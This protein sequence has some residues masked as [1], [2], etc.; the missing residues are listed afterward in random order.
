MYSNSRMVI[1][2]SLLIITGFLIASFSSFYVSRTTAIQALVKAEL[3]L[4][5][6]N[7]YTEVQRDLLSPKIVSSVMANDT[8]V[9]NWIKKGEQDESLIAAYLTR[10][11]QKY[12]AFT[13]F[14]VVEKTRNFYVPKGFVRKVATTEPRDEWYFRVRNN[15]QEIEVNIDPSEVNND[16]L[17]IFI[18]VRILDNAGEFIGAIGLGLKLD[19]LKS[20]LKEYKKKYGINVY[21]I[22]REGEIFLNP[23]GETN[24]PNIFQIPGFSDIAGE[25]VKTD[26]GQFRYTNSGTEY[27]L[28]TRYIKDVNLILMVEADLNH[29]TQQAFRSLVLNVFICLVTTLIVLFLLL[30][31]IKQHQ[32]K[33][34]K[35]AWRDYLTK[36]FNREAFVKSYAIQASSHQRNSQPLSILLIDLDHF[37]SINDQF[38]HSVGDQVLIRVADLLRQET[39][40]SDIVARWGGEEFVVL[41]SNADLTVAAALA[42]KIRI[43]IEQDDELQKIARKAQTA[44]IGLALCEQN[45]D[46][47]SNLKTADKNLYQAKDNG[48]NRVAF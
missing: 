46:L 36:L 6:D 19:I 25:I 8:F 44:S 15:T 33:I 48:R 10:I 22:T 37:K 39:R 21:F 1:T 20:R 26:A 30:R 43:K 18:N 42:E 23:E 9:K 5:S 12:H 40:A 38:G 31:T 11:T 45:S 14:L 7:I 35:I 16:E 47:N 41:L 32:S 17:T 2:V 29:A 24:L 34:E 27:L 3:P 4:T 28:N 13:A